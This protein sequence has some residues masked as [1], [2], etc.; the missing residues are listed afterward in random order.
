MGSPVQC[1]VS[2]EDISLVLDQEASPEQAEAYHQHLAACEGCRRQH[3]FYSKLRGLVRTSCSTESAPELLQA[4]L[5]KMLAAEVSQSQ[6]AVA[7]A[8]PAMVAAPSAPAAS[9]RTRATRTLAYLA[10]GAAAVA[11]FAAL[12]PTEK[13]APL[14]LAL[15]EDHSRCCDVPPAANGTAN[16]AQ[17]AQQTFGSSMPEMASPQGVQPYDVRVCP[18]HG[19]HVIHMLCRD[20]QQRVVSVY[21][22]PGRSF[23]LAGSDEQHPNVTETDGARVASWEHKGWMFSLVSRAP[24]DELITLAGNCLYGS[25]Q[26]VCQLTPMNTPGMPVQAIPASDR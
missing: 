25:P 10:A 6:E 16:P 18:V 2:S 26:A 9:L 5:R 22:A 7:T 17:L 14:A 12:R 11:S 20:S 3:E 13:S 24:K 19:N 23:A 8:A 21:T 4:R 1:P 15:S